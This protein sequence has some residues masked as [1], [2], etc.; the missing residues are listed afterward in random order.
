MCSAVVIGVHAHAE[1]D[2]L[3]E[4][5]RS[6]RTQGQAGAS[7]VLLPDG[8]DAALAAA[9]T[10]DPLLAGLPRWG[11]TEPLGAPACF[12]RLASRSDAAV[13]VFVE[14]GTVLGPGCLAMLLEAL[15]VPGRGLAGPSTN[16]SWNEQGAFG[17]AGAP[18][19]ART[20]ALARQRF[21]ATARTLEPL[22]SLAD[23]CVAVRREV[24]DAIGAADEDY[25]TGPC[26]EM[27]YSIRA[28]R[29]GFAGAWVCG[30]YAFRYPPTRRR[31]DSDVHQMAS[32]RHLYQDRFCGLRLRGLRGDYENHCRGDACE[33]FAP[34]PLITVRRP[35]GRPEPAG[36]QAASPPP[37]PPPDPSPHPLPLVTAIM[38]TRDRPDFALQ[39]IRCFLAQDYASKELLVLEDGASSLAGRLPD[40]P[41][42][43]HVVTGRA[44]RSIG[45]MRNEACQLAR[46]EI[47]AHWDDDDWYGPERLTRQVAA[48][49]DGQA[50]ITAL[51]GGL[52]FDLAAWRFWRL[53][54]ELHRRLFVR[55]VHGG[56]L[57]YRRRVWEEKVR[58]PDSSLAEDAVFLEQAVRSGARLEAVEGAGLFVYV[59][60]GSNAWQFACGLTGGAAGW[61][62][63]PEPGLPPEVRAFYAARSGAAPRGV[64]AASPAAPL[65]SCIMPTF[66][67]R[68]FVPQAV[69]CFLRQDYPAKELVIVDD[70]PEPVGDLLPADSSIVYH[71][72]EARM[73]LGTKRNLAC[74]LARGSIIVH[75]DD[76]DWSSPE[77]VSVQVAALTREGADVC[78]VSSL[79]YYDLV[80]ASAWRFTWPGAQRPWAAGPSLCFTKELWRGS[81]FPDVTIGEDTRFVFSPAVRRV[82]DVGAAGCVVGI[83]HPRNTAPK[84][85]RSP[86]W[87]PRS[88]REVEDLLGDDMPFYRSLAQ[89]L[90]GD[91][92]P[93]GRASLRARPGERAVRGCGR[94]GS[95]GPRG[96]PGPR[97]NPRTAPR[98]V[99]GASDPGRCGN[100]DGLRSCCPRRHA[101]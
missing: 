39:A 50:D 97:K 19:V 85:V 71:R 55:D 32:A 51:R 64:T 70:G 99:P 73:V 7:I 101:P 42:I 75:W 5:V 48:I 34:A 44:S 28:A 72:L 49:R 94:S 35:P 80:H 12:N 92:E 98:R 82:A 8:P 69:R 66:D 87:S 22:Y 59:R 53:R 25:G 62:S 91:A 84:S 26:W 33:H 2:H 74:D 90:R 9:L 6:V 23:F 83:V 95:R 65:V 47:V 52:V 36:A 63:V 68:S 88:M 10:A 89:G 30:A 56:T 93:A 29:A 58:F 57:V 78:G 14:S 100:C 77:R 60:H 46:G 54:P 41:R 40:D 61:E 45:A 20:A 17:G 16:R 37:P 18:D 4:T 27:D 21:G 43:R 31:R 96:C 13:V 79:L 24:I 76:D 3:A 15:A 67:R 86:H 11:T 1:P 81:P 38:P